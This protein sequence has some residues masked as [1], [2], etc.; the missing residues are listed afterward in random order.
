MR[1]ASASTYAGRSGLPLSSLASMS[2]HEAGVGDAGGLG[3]LDG[4]EGGERGVAVVGAAAAV[5]L[6]ALDDGRPRPE[7]LAPAGHLGLLVEVAVQQ[8]GAL[9][10]RRV[11]WPAPRT[12]SAA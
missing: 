3:A 12:R 6:V 5:E 2:T 11:G 9:G 8:H 10:E 4:D 7:A 1:S